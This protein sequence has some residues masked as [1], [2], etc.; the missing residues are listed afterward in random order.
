M[1]QRVEKF[2]V[3]LTYMFRNMLSQNSGELG[4]WIQ[5]QSWF[6]AAHSSEIDGLL[7]PD[8][9]HIIYGK[10]KHI[11]NKYNII[12]YCVPNAKRLIILC[13][14]KLKTSM[15]R[16]TNSVCGCAVCRMWDKHYSLFNYRFVY[17][18]MWIRDNGTLVITTAATT[19]IATPVTI[20]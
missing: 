9:L 11:I 19:A 8:V 18:K 20:Q 12:D 2:E 10:P 1:S 6:F 5:D 17:H 4:Q 13:R 15:I 7:A 16:L 14:R 3:R